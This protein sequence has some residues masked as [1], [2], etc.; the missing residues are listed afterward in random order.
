MNRQGNH[1]GVCAILTQIA[2]IAEEVNVL[3][4]KGSGVCLTQ[5]EQLAITA[6]VQRLVGEMSGLVT[7]VCGRV[8]RTD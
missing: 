5:A 7:S 6:E 2:M 3:A 1:D 4:L 8:G